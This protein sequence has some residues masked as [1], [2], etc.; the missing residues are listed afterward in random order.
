MCP[1]CD[2]L[3][4][5]SATPCYLIEKDMYQCTSP[6]TIPQLETTY[7]LAQT[8]CQDVPYAFTPQNTLTVTHTN[9]LASI[10]HCA[11]WQTTTQLVVKRGGYGFSL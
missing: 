4:R 5:P 2:T 8:C 3:R 6:C 11:K 9:P 7:L 1:S 10:C